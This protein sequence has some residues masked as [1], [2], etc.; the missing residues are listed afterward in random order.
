[1]NYNF[2][3]LKEEIL[4][5]ENWLKKEFSNIRTGLASVTILDNI[6]VENYGSLTSLNQVANLTV[7]DA[8]TIRIIPWDLS[9][10]KG[11][12][13][14]ITK[15]DLGVSVVVDG[16]G[17]RLFFPELTNERR[18]SF[19]KVAKDKLEQGK[20]SLRGERD[21]IWSDIQ[22]REKNNEISEDEKF[23]LK[24]EMQK[25]VD[26]AGKILVALFE[27]KEKEILG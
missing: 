5:I 15:S 2:I 25:I 18:Q 12:E 19:V 20:V 21:K 13:K 14:A 7:E 27:K 4:G 6:R 26:E 16:K 22:N 17:L 3:K 8:K 23:Q 1:M 11:I 24:N 9:Q 10:I